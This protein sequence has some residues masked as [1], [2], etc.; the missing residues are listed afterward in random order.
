MNCM[1]GSSGTVF[2]SSVTEWYLNV[3]RCRF[4]HPTTC[5]GHPR[6]HASANSVPFASHRALTRG[7]LNP[8]RGQPYFECVARKAAGSRLGVWTTPT[9][10]VH[11]FARG[12]TR[13]RRRALEG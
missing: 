11:R 2:P 6:G 13:P 12:E 9:N 3:L 8:L 1:H 10:A 7:R 5:G 4:E